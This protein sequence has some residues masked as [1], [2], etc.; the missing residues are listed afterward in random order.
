MPNLHLKDKD[1]MSVTEA[2]FGILIM[3]IVTEM[4]IYMQNTLTSKDSEDETT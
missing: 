3:M 2:T 1:V 4:M